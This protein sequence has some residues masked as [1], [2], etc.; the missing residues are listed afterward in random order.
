LP[1]EGE[2]WA[3]ID[4]R[5]Q[6]YRLIVFVAEILRK[7]GANR[8]ADMYR[9][10]PNTDF[11]DY[12]AE[13]TKLKRKRAKDVNFAKSYG[14]GVA[15]F[16]LMTGMSEE[17]SR[18]T[19]AQ[20]DDEMPFVREAADHYSRYAANNGYIKLIDGA[21]NHFNLWEPVFRDFAKEYEAK[22]QNTNIDTLPCSEA[23]SKR[24]KEDSKHPWYGERMKRAYTH[25]AFNRMIQGSAARQ[26]KKAM[27]DIDKAGF[28]PLLQ[29]HDELGFSFTKKEHAFECAQL[30]EQALPII[31][32]PML[33]ETKWGDSWGDL[34]KIIP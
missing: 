18:K 21:R 4:Y 22:R 19:M 31:T 24:R 6:E 29:L 34:E 27:V 30:M 13:I 5:Q 15:K 11:H 17:E 1:E 23:E 14:A 7:K 9:N 12:V 3:S 25:K 32:I 33:T 28:H 2:K 16:A 26:I 20:Y 10:D 8:A